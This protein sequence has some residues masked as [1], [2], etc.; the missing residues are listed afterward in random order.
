MKRLLPILLFLMF[1]LIPKLAGAEES[2]TF[3]P[4]ETE[5][6]PYYVGGYLE[7]KPVLLGLDH[8]SAFYKL[9]FFNDPRGQNL[10]EANGRIQL[11]G[12]YENNI[13]RIYAKTN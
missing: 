5:K 3:D 4:A 1:W 13:F 12:S 7:F 11:E 10:L 2:Y 6:K 8:D 9:R